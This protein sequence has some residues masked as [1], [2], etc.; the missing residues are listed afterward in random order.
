MSMSKRIELSTLVIEIF[1]ICILLISKNVYSAEHY[2][3]VY[4][5]QLYHHE[6][7]P[8]LQTPIISDTII[9]GTTDTLVAKNFDV[10]NVWLSDY[11]RPDSGRMYIRWKIES[12]D[13]YAP[14]ES[15]VLSDTVGHI[16]IVNP[17]RAYDTYRIIASF[18][19]GIKDTAFLFVKPLPK[20]AILR[21]QTEKNRR[22]YSDM[23][24]DTLRLTVT[25]TTVYAV[26][27]DQFGNFVRYA[28]HV[29][30]S[31]SD[32]TSIITAAGDTATGECILT[33]NAENFISAKIIVRDN[34]EGLVDTVTVINNI[35]NTA[36]KEN[37]NFADISNPVFY[38]DQGKLRIQFPF[39]ANRIVRFYTLSGNY[40]KTFKL[41]SQSCQFILPPG[42]YAVTS[43]IA[44]VNESASIRLVTGR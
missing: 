10:K 1:V 15:I 32:T 38:T 44:D 31:S 27:F 26:I 11:E 40:V 6:G 18:K 30:W 42:V 8:L 37:K 34:K 12:L 7:S 9:A 36:I 41:D 43:C 14:T 4:R 39:T 29:I 20:P 25:V 2:D 23:K 16:V 35:V 13:R 17:Y 28:T 24:I 33:A 3:M 5:V 19:G 22:I 21:I